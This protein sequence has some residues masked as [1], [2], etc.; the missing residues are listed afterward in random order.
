MVYRH[1]IDVLIPKG[2]LGWQ[3]YLH[4]SPHHFHNFAVNLKLFL[5]SLLQKDIQITPRKAGKRN[6]KTKKAENKNKMTD[7]SP[8]ISIITVNVNGLIHLLKYKNR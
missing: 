8:N 5:R 7:S 1:R 2:S 3:C 4:G 6:K